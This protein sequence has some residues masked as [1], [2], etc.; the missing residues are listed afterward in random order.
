M[1]NRT[2]VCQW[3]EMRKKQA[4]ERDG[5]I[6]VVGLLLWFAV[7]PLAEIQTIRSFSSADAFAWTF[8]GWL[9]VGI[10]CVLL[11]VDALL[12]SRDRTKR[13]KHFPQIEA[14]I[15]RRWE[16]VRK[17]GYSLGEYRQRRQRLRAKEI[18]FDKFG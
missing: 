6:G 7:T 3:K 11:G 15:D 5:E 12:A 2:V 10:P 14:V 4:R 1:L 13:R 16:S 18:K 17:G 9:F 8:T